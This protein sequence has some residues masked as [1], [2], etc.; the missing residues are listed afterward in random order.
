LYAVIRLGY[1]TQN[2]RYLDLKNDERV[3]TVDEIVRVAHAL[4]IHA[5]TGTFH[6]GLNP[7]G[8]TMNETPDLSLPTW[9]P[10]GTL[11]V[12]SQDP[13]KQAGAHAYSVQSR[14]WHALPAALGGREADV[15]VEAKGKEHAPTDVD[16][17]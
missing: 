13:A 15:M 14:D 8:L 11:H 6:H 7:G 3:W 5:I 9:S 2:L 4:G 16:I 1:P 17:G 12:S 10:R